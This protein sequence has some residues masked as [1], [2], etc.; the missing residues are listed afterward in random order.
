MEKRI[1]IVIPNYNKADTISQCLDAAFSSD[2]GNY[3]VIVVDDH[4]DDNSVDI[5]KKYPCKLIRLD[6]QSGTSSARNAGALSS[7]GDIIFFTDADC[8]L[9]KSTLSSINS[10]FSS[11]SRDTIIG[12]TYTRRPYDKSFFSF[13][14]SVFVNYFETKQVENPDYIAAHAMMMDAMVFRM[15]AGFPETFLPIIEDVEFSHRLRDSGCRLLMSPG[16]QVQHIFNFTFMGSLRNA[17]R[18]SMFWVMYSL[19]N[20]DLFTDSGCASRELK[21][22]VASCAFSLLFMI[23]GLLLQKPAVLYLVPAAL[24]F[25]SFIHRDLF[26][27]FNASGGKWFAC[28]AAFYYMLLYPLPIGLATIT[29]YIKHLMHGAGA[30][31]N[32][33]SSSKLNRNQI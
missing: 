28:R 19:S 21:I 16:I 33:S 5:V 32:T 7:D 9:Q 22:N 8:L 27:A 13:F 12:G 26:K 30:D 17:F 10:V 3:E 4:S 25:N 18:K 2:Y 14:Q 31:H 1:S 29:A 23:T 20:N 6:K 24:T 11:L 15:S